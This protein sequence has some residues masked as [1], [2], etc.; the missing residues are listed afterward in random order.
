M[1]SETSSLPPIPFT[2]HAVRT[3]LPPASLCL[4]HSFITDNRTDNPPIFPP[5]DLQHH[6]LVSLRFLSSRSL[7]MRHTERLMRRRKRNKIKGGVKCTLHRLFHLFSPPRRSDCVCP[8]P[9]YV[10]RLAE[11]AKSW[12]EW[13]GFLLIFFLIFIWIFLGR[14]ADFL[15]F[16]SK[17]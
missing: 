3:Q 17:N 5:R 14:P 8:W 1:G 12:W 6:Q 11:H 13:R 7:E 9:S 10:D 15:R 2:I 16:T 4:T